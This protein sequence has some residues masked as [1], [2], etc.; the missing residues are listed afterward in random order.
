[1]VG[2]DLW[3]GGPQLGAGAING[4]LGECGY[5]PAGDL[6]PAKQRMGG[7]VMIHLESFSLRFVFLPK[8]FESIVSGE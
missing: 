4:E 7:Y 8:S 6:S 3:L 2:G 1:M 5:R